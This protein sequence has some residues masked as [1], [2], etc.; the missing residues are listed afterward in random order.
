MSHHVHKRP[1]NSSPVF[2]G[3]GQDLLGLSDFG[4]GMPG[5]GLEYKTAKPTSDSPVAA[6]GPPQFSHHVSPSY[7]IAATL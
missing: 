7:T 3:A 5:S 6:G 1:A 4:G 2:E